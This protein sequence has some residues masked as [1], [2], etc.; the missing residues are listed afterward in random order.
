MSY[1]WRA[2]LIFSILCAAA[3]SLCSQ[4]HDLTVKVEGCSP[5]EGVLKISLY[6]APESFLSRGFRQQQSN[7]GEGGEAR[8]VF[9]GVPAGSYSIAIFQDIDGN[10]QLDMGLF[11][12]KEPYGFSNNARAL[13]GPPSFEEASFELTGNREMTVELK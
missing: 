4:T 1:I 9:E 2:I 13:F 5:K 11:G 12:P 10:G 6:D 8:F 3:A 7:L